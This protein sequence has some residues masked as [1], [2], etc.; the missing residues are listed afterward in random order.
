[1]SRYIDADSLKSS[2]DPLNYEGCENENWDHVTRTFEEIRAD[3]DEEPTVDAVPRWIPCSE[4]M[5][6]EGRY[7]LMCFKR[8]EVAPE[9]VTLFEIGR[10]L[11]DTDSNEQYWDIDDCFEL[12][13]EQ[14][15]QVVA[16]M[17]L[18]EVYKDDD[19]TE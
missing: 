1:M 13:D 6:E 12:H 19:A 18:P 2:Y 10:L 7:V 17:P 8:T 16:W 4:R 14:M 11:K 3:I 15:K 5:P 9:C